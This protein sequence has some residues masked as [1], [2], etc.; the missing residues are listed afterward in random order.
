MRL[1]LMSFALMLLVVLTPARPAAADTLQQRRPQFLESFKGI[2]GSAVQIRE[3]SADQHLRP[4]DILVKFSGRGAQKL[5]VRFTQAMIR[6]GQAL[7]RIFRNLDATTR[8]GS[9]HA[10]HDAIY[11]GGGKVAEASGGAKA[12]VVRGLGAQEGSY[13]QVYRPG[14]RALA[15]KAAEIAVRWANGR[16]KYGVPPLVLFRS[17]SFGPKA[18]KEALQFGKDA[19]RAG[20]PRGY[21]KMFCSQFVLAAYQAAVV[22]A[23]LARDPNLKPGAI[24]LP[25]AI[26][27]HASNTTPI[28]FH[29][30][31]REILEH[32]R[33]GWSFEGIVEV[34]K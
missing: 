14:D 23:Q 1:A 24:R 7:V 4:G 33:P 10:I 9:I 6:T 5:L 16:M 18:R 20:G 12:V 30:R 26:E 22:S 17:K 27:F 28:A 3:T 31:L 2:G 19:G 8:R 29:G 25:R 13:F 34:G 15:A 21:E 32:R 11:V